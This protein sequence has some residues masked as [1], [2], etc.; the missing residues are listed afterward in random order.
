MRDYPP[1]PVLTSIT[2]LFLLQTRT[3]AL[4]KF[5]DTFTVKLDGMQVM[6]AKPGMWMRSTKL[7][8]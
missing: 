4:E 1:P 7:E 8:M 6:V 3:D 5:Y 2:R